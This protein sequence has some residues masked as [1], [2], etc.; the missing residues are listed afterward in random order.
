MLIVLVCYLYLGDGSR[1]ADFASIGVKTGQ[2]AFYAAQ[3]RRIIIDAAR[4][5]TFYSA[6]YTNKI[7]FVQR[8]T[9]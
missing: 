5:R 7:S 9:P 6:K 4:L 8:F 1:Q 3:H 2:S